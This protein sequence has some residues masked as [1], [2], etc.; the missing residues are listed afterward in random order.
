[1]RTGMVKPRQA[2]SSKLW[3]YGGELDTG[4][5]DL[6]SWCTC[7]GRR[8][9]L[10]FPFGSLGTGDCVT[11][12]VSW[13]LGLSGSSHQ[14]YPVLGG[15]FCLLHWDWGRWGDGLAVFTQGVQTVVAQELS[16]GW[17]L[18]MLASL[19][20]WSLVFGLGHNV[21]PTRLVQYT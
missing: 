12:T 4:I 11:W 17:W 9:S 7:E 6:I 8:A 19:C 18:A 16:R 5:H 21:R 2:R 1:M 15:L 3:N 20:A 14:S 10:F 13:Q